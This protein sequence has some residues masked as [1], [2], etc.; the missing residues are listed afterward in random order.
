MRRVGKGFSGVDTPLF[1]GMLVA[2]QVDESVA[3]VNVDDV[4]AAGVA[5]ESA[6]DVNDDDVLTV[7]DEPSI[8]SPTL[9]TQPPPPSCDTRK[10]LD[11]KYLPYLLTFR[12][13]L[14]FLTFDRL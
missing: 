12:V 13:G 2:Q 11:F 7:V 4:P 9:P 6:A 8:P 1:E 5:D 3:E 10:F 14:D